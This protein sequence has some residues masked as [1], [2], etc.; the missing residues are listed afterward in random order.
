MRLRGGS[1]LAGGWPRR[2]L[3]AV[4]L[5]MVAPGAVAG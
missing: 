3:R 1:L 4:L 2:G 5:R